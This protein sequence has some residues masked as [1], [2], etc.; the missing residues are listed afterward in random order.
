MKDTKS[1]PPVHTTNNFASYNAAVE[2]ELARHEEARKLLQSK[3]WFLRAQAIGLI[4]AA[5]CL[6]LLI[7][8][9]IY[10]FF[11]QHQTSVVPATLTEQTPQEARETTKQLEEISDANKDT[12]NIF[13][14]EKKFTVVTST[15]MITGEHV[16]TAEEFLPENLKS[17]DWV[18]CYISNASGTSQRA[19]YLA[20]FK[21]GV[22]TVETEDSYLLENA[23]PLCKFP[24]EI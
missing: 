20:S 15:T 14:I 13:P 12:D 22:K 8:F 5:I 21:D 7:V 16:V 4:I 2:L 18:Y 6:L 19:E 17:P 24:P 1:A 10:Y 11:P 3:S 23:L 9:G